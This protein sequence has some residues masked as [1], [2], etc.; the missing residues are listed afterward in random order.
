MNT[1]VDLDIY[2]KGIVTRLKAIQAESQALQTETCALQ[3]QVE[4]HLAKVREETERTFD[5][6]QEMRKQIL[7]HVHHAPTEATFKLMMRAFIDHH[8]AYRVFSAKDFLTW[9]LIHD[10]LPET[11]KHLSTNRKMGRFMQ[12]HLK[13]LSQCGVV[14]I[15]RRTSN[16]SHYQIVPEQ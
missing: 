8:E 9:L 5:N 1:D 15:E 2:I 7:N 13:L 3:T 12:M 14:H 16:L 4:S 11:M 6:V 10:M